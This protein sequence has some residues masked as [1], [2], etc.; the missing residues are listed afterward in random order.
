MAENSVHKRGHRQV[1]QHRHRV[2]GRGCGGEGCTVEGK[3]D[4]PLLRI[5]FFFIHSSP[6][7]LAEAERKKVCFVHVL[8]VLPFFLHFTLNLKIS[9]LMPPN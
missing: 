8:I 3:D 7:F 5:F 4:I 2:A 1:R 6:E 9:H